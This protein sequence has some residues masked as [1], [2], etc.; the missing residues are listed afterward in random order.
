MFKKIFLLLL[1]ASITAF[2]ETCE[3]PEIQHSFGF[4]EMG[5]QTGFY[6]WLPGISL[7]GGYRNQKDSRGYELSMN[8]S[9]SL[10]Y[11]HVKGK[12]LYLIYPTPKEDSQIYYGLGL[13]GGMFFVFPGCGLTAPFIS[14]EI[15]FGCQY[16]NAKKKDRFVE[17][18]LSWPFLYKDSH[19]H[20]E[21]WKDMIIPR[22]GFRYCIGF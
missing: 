8:F 10:I 16:Q 15:A 2:S 20:S 5:L 13:G 4:L 22:V 21:G 19:H 12:A 3:K 9:S 11:T 1:T 14:P 6:P 17:I 18:G 7:G